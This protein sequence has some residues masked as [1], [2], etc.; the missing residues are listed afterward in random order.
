MSIEIR[1]HLDYFRL[2][3]V[4]RPKSRM[5]EVYPHGPPPVHGASAALGHHRSA[6]VRLHPSERRPRLHPE[7]GAR[8]L[9]A[10]FLHRTGMNYQAASGGVQS[11]P[12]GRVRTTRMRL[13]L[14]CRTNRTEI[15]PAM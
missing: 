1:S 5:A 2:E 6:S 8:A 4:I 7:L 11:A 15:L 3:P 12:R 13:V 14:Y 9:R 10:P